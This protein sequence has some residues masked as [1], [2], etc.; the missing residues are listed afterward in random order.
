MKLPFLKFD[1]ATRKI[2]VNKKISPKSIDLICLIFFLQ[3]YIGLIAINLY[4]FLG[5]LSI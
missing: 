3:F 2:I 1:I 4:K 5:L